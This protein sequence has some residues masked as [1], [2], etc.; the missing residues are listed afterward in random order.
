MA[1]PPASR[2]RATVVAMPKIFLL[3]LLLLGARAAAADGPSVGDEA[4]RLLQEYIRIDTT[5]PPGGE[6]RAARWL[7]EQLRREGLEATVLDL[8]GGR[9]NLVARMEGTDPTAPGIAL[10]HHM[11]VVPADPSRWSFP[12]F[13]GARRGH[14]LLGRGTLDIKG[15]GVVDLMTLAGFLRRGERLRGDVVYLAV[16]DEEEDGIGSQAMVERFRPHLRGVRYVLDEGQS[17]RADPAGEPEACLVA[18]GEKTPLWLEIAFEGAAGHGSLPQRDSS[19]NR[20]LQAAGRILRHP[21]PYDVRPE[22]LGQLRLQLRGRDLSRLPGWRG[23]L[24][25]SLRERA[26]VH[27]LAE[28]PAVAALVMNTLSITQLTGSDKINTVPNRAVLGLD[29]RLLPGVSP[30]EFQAELARVVRDPGARFTVKFSYPDSAASPPDSPLMDAIRAAAARH[31]P[32]VPVMPALLT[33]STDSYFYRKAGFVTYG[34]ESWVLTQADYELAHANDERLDVRRLEPAVAMLTDVL[35]HLNPPS[36]RP[37]SSH[38]APRP[39]GEGP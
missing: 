33:A 19:V 6:A 36:A 34:F 29:C 12:P 28:E 35:R 26:F 15:K 18:V 4:A 10:L 14:E 22:V 8:G 23:D 31:H 13:E 3:L 24:E 5:N 2:R 30:V 11:D 1:A 25:S 17:L 9:A 20:A 16:A 39:G 37:R 7:Q 38:T 27:A 21:W 32:G